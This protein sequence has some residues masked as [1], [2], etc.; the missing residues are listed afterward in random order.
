MYVN[1][2]GLRDAQRASKTPLR[3]VSLRRF[4]DEVS[5][6]ISGLREDGPHQCE[7]VPSNP[8]GAWI[9][10]KDRKREN[11]FSLLE[12]RHH[13][14]LSLL[15]GISSSWVSN[16]D[17]NSPSASKFSGFLTR[18]EFYH[19][20]SFF[21]SLQMADYGTYPIPII[22]LLYLHLFIYISI[23]YISC[24]LCF[25]QEPWIILWCHFFFL[26]PHL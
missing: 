13:F 23:I 26:W 17:W 2:I 15:I 6:W 10:R 21:S 11:L 25:S 8:P 22:N 24:C 7:W 3:D 1:L 20:H 14:L 19:Q 12:L 18:I 4:L 16:L 5:I 9:K